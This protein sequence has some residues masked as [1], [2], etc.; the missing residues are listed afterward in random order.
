MFPALCQE[1]LGYPL[2]K[3]GWTP[4]EGWVSLCNGLRDYQPPSKSLTITPERK[5]ELVSAFQKSIRRGDMQMA[6]SLVSAMDSLGEYSYWWRRVCVV[7]LE[8][9]GLADD[10]LAAFVVAC[11]SVFTPKKTGSK[12][13]DVICYLVEKLCDLP[14]RS[15]IYCSYAVIE[16]GA[17][18]GELPEL[19]MEDKEIVSAILER[20]AIV[21][22]GGTPW[23]A[24]QKKNDWRAAGLVKYVGLRLPLEM[25][26]VKTPV[27]PYKIIHDLPSCAYDMYTRTGL[28]VLHR[29]VRGV[30][31]AEPIREF[32]R[33]N[34]V[35]DAHRALGEALFFEEGG[36][37]RGEL[38]YPA[39]SCLEQRVFAH[40]F[41][42]PLESWL[43]LRVLVGRALKVGVIDRVREEVLQQ[44]YGQ[45]LLGLI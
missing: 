37:I 13:Y 28:R 22:A 7:G 6:L 30:K 16:P 36:R 41:G 15:R 26:T 11:S 38:I 5:W 32:F 4:S 1:L 3:W 10:T 39:L 34:T 44:V 14:N 45:M 33:Q 43:H 40:Q 18:K 31:G 23:L 35:K 12:G 8:D 25:T 19:T 21:R 17:T 2:S 29:L 27:P 9:V 42:L 24:W 20:N